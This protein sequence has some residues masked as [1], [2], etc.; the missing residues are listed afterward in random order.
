VAEPGVDEAG[1]C[2]SLKPR[3]LAMHTVGWLWPPS[4]V[5]AEGDC[6]L[7]QLSNLGAQL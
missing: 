1:E 7:H 4:G 5:G 6:R 3:E 2:G